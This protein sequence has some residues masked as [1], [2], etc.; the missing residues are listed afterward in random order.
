MSSREKNK[1]GHVKSVVWTWGHEMKG[2]VGR[3]KDR[4]EKCHWGKSKKSQIT[5]ILGLQD[6]NEAGQVLHC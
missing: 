1:F 4:Q 6:T 3:N 2:W 5:G